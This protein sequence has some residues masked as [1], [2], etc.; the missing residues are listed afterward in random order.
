MVRTTKND[1]EYF[2]KRCLYWAKELG[3]LYYRLYFEHESIEGKQATY[4]VNPEAS[5]V[6]LTFSKEWSDIV[7]KTK[8]SIN[9]LA[10]HEMVEILLVGLRR[11]A[12][13]YI[14]YDKLNEETHKIVSAIEN[15]VLGVEV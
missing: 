13:E 9:H 12:G 11:W 8:K 1:F 10:F 3:L 14:Q 6:V 7:P 4:S 15:L 5:E 2:K